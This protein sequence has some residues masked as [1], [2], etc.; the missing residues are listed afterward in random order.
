MFSKG[1]TRAR[2]IHFDTALCDIQSMGNLTVGEA[3][4][5]IEQQGGSI[6]LGHTTKSG[7]YE[8]CRT[9]HFLWVRTLNVGWLMIEVLPWK[10]RVQFPATKGLICGICRY[11]GQPVRLF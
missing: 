6:L 4:L 1:L 8:L 11:A 3:F 10:P 7:A 9:I 5:C 2:Q